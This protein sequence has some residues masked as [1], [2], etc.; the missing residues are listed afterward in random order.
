MVLVA[1]HQGLMHVGNAVRV[2]GRNRV[3]VDQVR[4]AAN[5]ATTG[6]RCSAVN[7]GEGWKLA[8]IG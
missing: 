6:A 7:A 5:A 1:A 8:T 2:P 3:G 4:R